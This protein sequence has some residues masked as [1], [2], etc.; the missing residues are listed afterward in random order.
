MR[1]NI[2]VIIKLL[3]LLIMALPDSFKYKWV[4]NYHVKCARNL[5]TRR[6]SFSRIALVFFIRCR[7]LCN[8]VIN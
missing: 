3:V 8:F 4:F 7:V 6:F 1:Y 5:S 2:Q